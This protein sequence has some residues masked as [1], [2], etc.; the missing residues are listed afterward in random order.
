MLIC[1]TLNTDNFKPFSWLSRGIVPTKARVHIKNNAICE[2]N[3]PFQVVC[4]FVALY[5][6]D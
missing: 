3:V 6:E 4:A 1:Y 5:S 2:P